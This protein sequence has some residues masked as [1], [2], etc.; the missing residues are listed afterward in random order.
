MSDFERVERLF[1]LPVGELVQLTPSEWNEA[2]S[3]I[4]GGDLQLLANKLYQLCIISAR[5]GAY[6]ES[7]GKNKSHIDSVREQNRLAEKIRAALDF[8][9]PKDDINF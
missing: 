1:K 8:Q 2:F 3:D 4:H 5:M 6:V 9:Q 7:R